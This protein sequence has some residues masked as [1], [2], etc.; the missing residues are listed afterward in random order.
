MSPSIEMTLLEFF[1]RARRPLYYKSKLNQLRN[2]EVLSLGGV[3]QSIGQRRFAYGQAY[4]KK[5]TK[6]QYTF[7]GL[8]TLPSKP[9]RQDCWIQGTFTLSKGVMRFE[10]SVTIAHLHGFFKVCRYLG[11]HKRAC[12][13]QYHRAS[14]AYRQ[15]QRQWEQQWED[16]ENEY[17]THLEPED[18][19]YTLSIRIGPRPSR[20]DFGCWFLAHGHSPLFDGEVMSFHHLNLDRVDFDTHDR[21]VTPPRSALIQKGEA[22]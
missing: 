10:S 7:V 15:A 8:W 2:H 17:T 18:F 1:K 6:G 16:S 4:L 21:M 11:V 19:S 20:S 22:L 12:V 13:T 14:E 5:L 3:R 9:E